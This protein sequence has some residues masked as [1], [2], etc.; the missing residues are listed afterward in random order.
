LRLK[1]LFLKDGLLWMSF[2]ARNHSSVDFIPGGMR[3]VVQDRKRVRRTA[4]QSIE[5]QLVYVGSASELAGGGELSL[6]AALHALTIAKG[7]QL[8]VEWREAD[9]GRRVQ[10]VIRG[11]LLLRAKKID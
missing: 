6:V 4:V 11:K 10:L 2:R 8:V 7:K 5:V 1:G 3:F 9:D